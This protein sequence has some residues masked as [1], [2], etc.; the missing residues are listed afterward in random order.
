MLEVK[1]RILRSV[2]GYMDRSAHKSRKGLTKSTAATFPFC[3][4]FG[5]EGP[6]E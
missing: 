4:V 5:W 1:R 3:V 2:L 6:A